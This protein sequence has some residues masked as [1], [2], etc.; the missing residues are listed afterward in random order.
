MTRR[1]AGLL[2]GSGAVALLLASPLLLRHV[3]F[4]RVRQ[5]EL[6]GVRYHS[7]QQIIDALGLARDQSLFAS[8]RKGEGSLSDLPGVIDVKIE[9]KVPGT[10]K[11]EVLE[12]QP[13]AFLA[14]PS[15]LTV[16]DADANQMGYDPAAGGFDL[17]FVEQRDS[18]LLHALAQVQLVDP[19][20]FDQVDAAS[21]R[22]DGTVV[23]ELGQ[24]RIM[25]HGVPDAIQIE[26]LGAVRNHM[27]ETGRD[28]Q[29]LDARFEAQIVVRRSNG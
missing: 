5:V 14:T 7:P 8:V 29:Q 3:A 2:L 16:L 28:Y 4:F 12:L 15:G 21:L 27:A 13:I 19:G 6:V 22:S 10:L 23:L 17:P 18:V 11:I 1:S 26:T 20:L 9:R 24:K 25:L